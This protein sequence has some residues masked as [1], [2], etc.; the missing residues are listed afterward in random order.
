ML[1]AERNDILTDV[2][3]ESFREN[4]DGF[5][6]PMESGTPLVRIYLGGGAYQILRR[7]N[8]ASP[9]LP[10]VTAQAAEFDPHAFRIWRSSYSVVV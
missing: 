2:I 1:V 3:S 8:E 10:I 6:Y 4:L 9:W 5:W 7:R